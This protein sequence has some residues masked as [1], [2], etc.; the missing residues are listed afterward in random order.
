MSNNI[1]YMRVWE[2]KGYEGYVMKYIN[3]NLHRDG[4]NSLCIGTRCFKY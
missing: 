4:K 2:Y 1:I 3:N